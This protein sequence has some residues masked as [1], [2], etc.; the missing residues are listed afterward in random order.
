MNL[1]RKI[2]LPKTIVSP[3]TGL[4]KS[5][6]FAGGTIKQSMPVLAFAAGWFMLGL[7]WESNNLLVIALVFG[8]IA[9]LGIIGYRSDYH[10]VVGVLHSSK[11]KKAVLS[12]IWYQG[13]YCWK[14]TSFDSI[15]HLTR[16]CVSDCK[17]HA[18]ED[19]KE[20]EVYIYESAPGEGLVIEGS[21]QITH[22][23]IRNERTTNI[24]EPQI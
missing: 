12:G 22:V 4:P 15:S 23:N 7:F 17:V 24:R 8:A 19:P 20:V 13:E 1:F 9:A 14:I 5:V 6:F 21:V 3:L 2:D 11:P 16:V 10:Y 18:F